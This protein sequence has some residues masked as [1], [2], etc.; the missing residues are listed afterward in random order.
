MALGLVS[1][2]RTNTRDGRKLKKCIQ[3]I[4]AIGFLPTVSLRTSFDNYVASTGARR[5]L[6]QFPRLS[7]FIQSVYNTYV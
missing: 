3:K 5:L 2:Y 4:M 7:E 1:A 6:V